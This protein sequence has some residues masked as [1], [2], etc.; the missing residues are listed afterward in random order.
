MKNERTTD[1]RQSRLI[2]FRYKARHWL[3]LYQ[4]KDSNGQIV[5]GEGFLAPLK[6]I[7]S[8]LDNH[9]KKKADAL[10]LRLST[11]KLVGSSFDS[12]RRRR[13]SLSRS[14]SAHSSSSNAPRHDPLRPSNCF[15]GRG[16]RC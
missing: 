1:R 14:R 13:P 12:R 3:Q 16:S 5:L 4:L 10:G 9:I 11:K 6:K 2:G 7:D 15:P 8:F